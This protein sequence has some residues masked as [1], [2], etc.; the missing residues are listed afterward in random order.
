MQRTLSPL[1]ATHLIPPAA[2]LVL[3][4]AWN[5][6][7]LR[8]IAS[9]K[10]ETAALQEKISIVQATGSASQDL[11]IAKSESR[12]A[13][14]SGK[15]SRDWQQL[16]ALMDESQPASEKARI[17][18]ITEF[19]KN[20]AEMSREEMI[21]ALDE[22]DGLDLT[23]A[24]RRGLES[25]IIDSLIEQDPEYA[26]KRF[27]D[28]IVSDPDDIGSQ[29]DAMDVETFVDNARLETEHQPCGAGD[30]EHLEAPRD[31][32]VCAGDSATQTP[33]AQRGP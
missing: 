1:K 26:L 10:K 9:G 8:T 21:S 28:R 4:I 14:P 16:A 5:A 11:A 2:A 27:A 3:V 23:A 25:E 15:V 12:I 18:A 33:D 29:H 32:H 7:E 30:Q 13:Q 17:R 20:L 6:T 24:Q 19:Q 22:I 31:E